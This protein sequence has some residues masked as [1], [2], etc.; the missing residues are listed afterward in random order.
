MKAIHDIGEAQGSFD[1][2]GDILPAVAEAAMTPSNVPGGTPLEGIVAKLRSLYQC[3]GVVRAARP[4]ESEETSAA[5]CT[6]P[7]FRG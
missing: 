5:V 3:H 4:A 1:A 7:Q 6:T 2:F